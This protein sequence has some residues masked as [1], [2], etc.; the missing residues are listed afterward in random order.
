MAIR[1]IQ[2]FDNDG[3]PLVRVVDDANFLATLAKARNA[4][5]NNNTSLGHTP[6]P[7][8]TLTTA[9]LS[10]I[11][12]TLTDQVDALTRQNTALILFLLGQFD[13]VSGT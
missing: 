11:V 1:Q 4:I 13:D 2:G 12:R 8:G 10:G 9:Q 5:A 6:I 7:T 3:N